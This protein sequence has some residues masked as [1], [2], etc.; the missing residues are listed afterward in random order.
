[1]NEILYG[2]AG[3]RTIQGDGRA[4]KSRLLMVSIYS[5]PASAKEYGVPLP[6]MK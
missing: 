6:T 1:M 3:G 5:K 4:W 2:P